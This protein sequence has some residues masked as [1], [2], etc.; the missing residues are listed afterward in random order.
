MSP[1]RC[2]RN[3]VPVFVVAALHLCFCVGFAGSTKNAG[4]N[5]N[6]TTIR[7]FTEGRELSPDRLAFL[8]S[9]LSD[10]IMPCCNLAH[11]NASGSL[12]LSAGTRNWPTDRFQP[13]K[14]QGRSV[15]VTISATPDT[16]ASCALNATCWM[17]ENRETL[18]SELTD[19]AQTFDLDG[20]TLDWEF[21]VSFNWSY[22][23]KTWAYLASTL[24]AEANLTVD[25]CV[26]S[27]EENPTWSNGNPPGEVYF[28]R[29]P[30]AGK[31]TDMAT[32]NLC[33]HNNCTNDQLQYNLT[34]AKYVYE[35]QV[36]PSVYGS[37]AGGLQGRATNMVKLGHVRTDQ[38]S[39][40]IAFSDDCSPVPASS[41]SSPSSSVDHR[42]NA[43]GIGNGIAN[44]NGGGDF[45]RGNRN[46][47]DIHHT[48]GV[49]S[50]VVGNAATSNETSTHGWT[51]ATLR[52]FLDNQYDQGVRNIDIWCLTSKQVL[53]APCPTCPWVDD[54]LARW[55]LKG[56]DNNQ[57]PLN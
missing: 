25:I 31:L 35:H 40:G 10:G 33:S 29:Y 4:T 16:V 20:F 53:T 7:W 39:P 38:L 18:A 42:H 1:T 37:W 55:K 9:N 50:S 49:M 45:E 54:E 15:T 8:T 13:L 5:P 24:G 22:F 52:A 2:L 30:W 21:G 6:A 57:Q 48:D 34:T 43:N 26:D 36:P 3:K 14:Q 32:Y 19:F 27:T 28:R 46:S 17:W 51:A 41:P 44:A 56:S 11:L 12:N 23:N 47:G